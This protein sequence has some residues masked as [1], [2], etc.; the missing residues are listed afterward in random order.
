[1][2][3]PMR[4]LPLTDYGEAVATAIAWLGER[5]LLARPINVVARR[6]A[7]R[8]AEEVT[9]GGFDPPKRPV[10]AG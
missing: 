8:P 7:P 1:M 5:Y 4:S 3:R 10:T 9:G 2:R 6:G